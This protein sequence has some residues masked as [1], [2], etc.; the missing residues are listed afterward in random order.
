MGTIVSREAQPP[1]SHAP[2]QTQSGPIV[3][4]KASA[5]ERGLVYKKSIFLQRADSKANHFP[6]QNRLK[7]R[8]SKSSV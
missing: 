8:S 6:M 5:G 7:I 2:N 4:G 1:K 3:L